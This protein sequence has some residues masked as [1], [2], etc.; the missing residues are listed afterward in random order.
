MINKR[1]SLIRLLI[2]PYSKK[3]SII[4]HI[5]ILLMIPISFL[6]TNNWIAPIFLSIAV[7]IRV[8]SAIYLIK[9]Y[10]NSSDPVN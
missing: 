3:S 6:I 1:S 10:G 7:L 5:L 2:M 9:K 8:T 4:T